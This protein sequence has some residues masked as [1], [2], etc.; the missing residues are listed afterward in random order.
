MLAERLDVVGGSS[1]SASAAVVAVVVFSALKPEREV[2]AASGV[3]M[4][5]ARTRSP[6]GNCRL[7]CFGGSGGGAGEAGRVAAFIEGTG[8][9]GEPGRVPIL[10]LEA[11]RRCSSAKAGEAN[12]KLCGLSARLGSRFKLLVGNEMFKMDPGRLFFRMEVGC[13]LVDGTIGGGFVEASA[14]ATGIVKGG[15][16]DIIERLALRQDNV[17]LCR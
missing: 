1:S 9:E 12:G 5:D 15:P 17:G 10:T 16:A 4:L 14:S 8:G 7:S 2:M 11:R 3:L 13:R 6:F